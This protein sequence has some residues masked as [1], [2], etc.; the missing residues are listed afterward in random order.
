MYVCA[1][2]VIYKKWASVYED[3]YMNTSG[4]GLSGLCICVL[5]EAFSLSL[6]DCITGQL[7]DLS[8]QRLRGP[9]KAFLPLFL[10][11]AQISFGHTVVCCFYEH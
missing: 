4:S 2:T 3:A 9:L 10:L 6:G 8:H 11:Y 7:S 5:L 1:E